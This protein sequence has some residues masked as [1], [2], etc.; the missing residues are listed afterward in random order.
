MIDITSFDLRSSNVI[1]ENSSEVDESI[2]SKN[3][4]CLLHLK[5][6]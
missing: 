1:E 5:D 2:K 3:D 4:M 6:L